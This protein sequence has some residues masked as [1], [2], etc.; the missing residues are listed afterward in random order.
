M[1]R[2]KRVNLKINPDKCRWFARRTKLLGHIISE[3][4]IE[5]DPD[6]I[7]ALREKKEPTNVKQVQQFLGLANYYRKFINNFAKKAAP[8]YNLLNKDVKWDWDDNCKNSFETLIL[9]LTSE[10]VLRQPDMERQ[11]IIHTDASNEAVGAI[12]SQKDENNNEYVIAYASK[13][14]KNYEKHMGISEKEMAGVVFGIKEFR[15]YIFGSRYKVKVVT[16]HKALQYLLSLKDPTGKLAR[17]AMFL[18]QFDIEI[19]YRKGVHHTNADYM[20]RPVMAIVAVAEE[21]AGDIDISLK[22][23]DPYEDEALMY[24]IQYKRHRDGESKK[25]INRIKRL[26]NIYDWNGNSI[27]MRKNDKW[28]IV[29]VKDERVKIIDKFHAMSAHFGVDSTYN[30][31]REQ[32][33]WPKLHKD[34]EKFKKN[35]KTCIRNDDFLSL[36]HPAMANKVTNINDEVTIDFSWGF[37]RTE[38]SEIGVMYIQEAVSRY[39]RTYAMRSKSAEEI[40][41][42]LIDWICIFG[43]CKRI[44]SDNEPALMSEVMEILKR[45]I[46]LEWHKVT[47]SYS[48][49]HNGQIERYVK[50]FGN[51]LRKLAETN[52]NKWSDWIQ[53]ID[54]AYN[55]RVHTTTKITPYECLFGVK[56]NTFDDWNAY[57]GESSEDALI[58]RSNQ[59]KELIEKR[60]DVLDK[61]DISKDKQMTDQNVRTKRIQRTFL[62]NG[63]VVYRKNEGI[64]TKLEPRWIG[65]YKIFDHDERGNYSLID[66]VGNGMPKKFPIEKLKLVSK[67]QYIADEIDEI[68]RILD[69]K[70]VSNKLEYLVEWKKGDKSWVKEEDFQTIEVINDY[71]RSKSSSDPQQPEKRKRGR[72]KKPA[73]GLNMVLS[74]IFILFCL[75]S[76]VSCRERPKY[77]SKDNSRIVDLNAICSESKNFDETK[78]K[79][80]KEILLLNKLHHEVYG[81]GYR[82]KAF[83]A[84]MTCTYSY[85]W[86]E[87]GCP[88]TQWSPIRLTSEDCWNMVR[89]KRC[90]LESNEVTFDKKLN[91]DNLGNCAV[92]VIPTEEYHWGSTIKRRAYKCSM[93][94]LTIIADSEKE[95]IY[96][97]NACKPLDF[98]CNMGYEIIVWNSTI[99]H[100]CPY[101]IIDTNLSYEFT[102]NKYFVSK[103]DNLLFEITA[104]SKICEVEMYETNEGIYIANMSSLDTLNRL[105][106]KLNE[107]NHFA[108]KVLLSNIDYNGYK[109]LRWLKQIDDKLCRLYESMLWMLLNNNG[110]YLRLTNNKGLSVIFQSDLGRIYLLDCID[111]ERMLYKTGHVKS[112][113]KELPIVA[114]T[115]DK[116]ILGF[117]NEQDIVTQTAELIS[118]DIDSIVSPT[119]SSFVVEERYQRRNDVVS[120][121]SKSEKGK[122]VDISMTE[123]SMGELNTHH[124]S[125]VIKG[126]DELRE[127]Y[128][129]QRVQYGT[130]EYYVRPSKDLNYWKPNVFDFS[131]SSIMDKISI[132]FYRVIKYI[133]LGLLILIILYIMLR[134]RYFIL[135]MLRITISKFTNKRE[136]NRLDQPNT[137]NNNTIQLESLSVRVENSGQREVQQ[138]ETSAPRTLIASS[139]GANVL[140]SKNEIEYLD[141]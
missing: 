14:F 123:I 5:M 110:K 9:A 99:L 120:E 55:T 108:N 138:V 44:R 4:G 137:A 103:K 12:L 81:V 60:K 31:I 48:P 33:I 75:L 46:G 58:R 129:I 34:V 68:K 96:I 36:N 42:K 74:C 112:C 131:F 13:L 133:M 71:W 57:E 119:I 98:K 106:V 22:T 43:P 69:D 17:W 26:A 101:E 25:Q 16:D 95:G 35:C 124:S 41:E 61:L 15:P 116:K 27:I 53:F 59:I 79:T 87:N 117:I 20:S 102:E 139:N 113:H 63:T 8:L 97:N 121:V 78:L 64:I 88:L 45:S 18:S 19:E 122:R 107:G 126:Y 51:A 105:G 86:Q 77:C 84:N 29:P 82:C 50:T 23:V 135:K 114:W 118:C 11:Y 3:N 67:E 90:R 28:L 104:V 130:S 24:Y 37:D 56:C 38:K 136:V 73:I 47:A 30:R 65:P 1:E 93:Q 7:K 54:L 91:C 10:P 40:A 76:G 21:C 127:L 83:M 94:L 141:E 66:Q 80:V 85:F 111:I 89:E 70:T 39:T 128:D 6:K 72:P 2:F 32:Y 49:S 100:K 52:R 134:Y 140:P 92:E 125:L 132:V 115:K 62:E 109:E